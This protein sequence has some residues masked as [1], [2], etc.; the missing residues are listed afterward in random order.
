MPIDE[1]PELRHCAPGIIEPVLVKIHQGKPHP[2]VVSGRERMS[3]QTVELD[4]GALRLGERPG[5]EPRAAQ[6]GFD[7]LGRISGSFRVRFRRSL[8]LAVGRQR[9]D[10]GI[11]GADPSEASADE[12]LEQTIQDR[13][14]HSGQE[15]DGQAVNGPKRADQLEHAGIV[16]SHRQ[17][18]GEYGPEQGNAAH[19]QANQIERFLRPAVGR[20]RID[21]QRI[22]A[23]FKRRGAQADKLGSVL[24]GSKQRGAPPSVDFRFLRGLNPRRV[25]DQALVPGKAD[26]DCFH[27]Y[28]ARTAQR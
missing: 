18:H 2:N 4:R 20:G 21:P 27:R 8:M 25:R 19:G 16:S 12:E 24:R 5:K 13:L 15:P 6:R 10:A 9:F 28:V 17:H 1:S 3:A 26:A 7:S 23:V 14:Q 22:G 11:A